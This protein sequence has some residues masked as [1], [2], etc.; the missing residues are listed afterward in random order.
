MRAFTFASLGLLALVA[1]AGAGCGTRSCREHTLLVT[2]D[3]DGPATGADGLTVSVAVGD[4]AAITTPVKLSNQ[5]HGTLEVTFPH[6]YPSGKTVSVTVAAQKGGA[7]VGSTSGTVMLSGVCETLALHFA[8]AAAGDMGGA[9]ACVPLTSCPATVTCGKASDGCGGNLDCGACTVNALYEP[10]ANSGDILSI[11]GR[12]GDSATVNFPG[13]TSVDATVLSASRLSVAVPAAAGSGLLTVSSNGVTTNAVPFNHAS[14]AF[15]PQSFRQLN[16]QANYARQSPT[17][18]TQRWGSGGI[19]TADRVWIIGGVAQS[20]ESPLASIEEAHIEGDGALRG[21]Q[22]LPGALTHARGW[23]SAT[24]VGNFVYVIGGR[25]AAVTSEPTIERA[26]I[27]ADGSLG[28]FSVVPDLS[29][30]TPRYAHQIVVLGGWLY[31]LGG[32]SGNWCGPALKL[33]SIE[34][35]PIAADGTLGPFVDAGVALTTPRPNF[36]VAVSGG[37]LYAI[38]GDN[39]S[40]VEYAPIAADG[41]LGAFANAVGVVDKSVPL[42]AGGTAAVLGGKLWV[43]SGTTQSAV[44]HGDG[45]IENFITGAGAGSNKQGYGT[46]IGDYFYTIASG[47]GDCRCPGGGACYTG[48]PISSQRVLLG[49]GALGAFANSAKGGNLTVARSHFGVAVTPNAVYAIGGNSAA[50]S[51][52]VEAAA[53]GA[54][55]SLGNF[56]PV[57][58]V[59][60]ATPRSSTASAIVGDHVYVVG[61]LDRSGNALTS[62]EGAAINSDGTLGPFQAVAASLHTGGLRSL[63]VIGKMLCVF[64]SG[65]AVECAPIASDG[66]LG[67]FAV[68]TAP[69]VVGGGEMVAVL[70]N[71]IFGLDP[72][73]MSEATTS[74]ASSFAGSFMTYGTYSFEPELGSTIVLGGSYYLLGGFNGTDT[75]TA[76]WRIAVDPVSDQ[77]GASSNGP[78]LNFK[79]IGQTEVLLHSH[80][81]VIGG[82]NGGMPE[83]APLQ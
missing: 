18:Q 14:Y 4:G 62:V 66:T 57:A 42:P 81:Y 56:T 30:L 64:S 59:A 71:D 83:L 20:D 69:A 73:G 41:T 51:A 13:G 26:P 29:L 24:R 23:T 65:D 38:S 60:L 34:R 31:V 45:T 17:L 82:G 63:A 53:I 74:N 54:D 79:H 46:F 58:G 3:I 52:D 39:L 27:N 6:G 33:A 43:F 37:F 1:V 55:G 70:S 12:F 77:P 2:V 9:D 5:S 40:T 36:S 19:T 80:V 21:F 8:G 35:A 10:T 67:S 78:A 15:A 28:A 50:G 47:Y 22:T 44:I 25:N 75:S 68:T 7:Q 72:T 61:G 32:Y 11:E 76:V 48:I 49:S 16:E